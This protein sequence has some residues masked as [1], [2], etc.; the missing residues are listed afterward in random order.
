MSCLMFDAYRFIISLPIDILLFCDENKIDELSITS[1]II[2]YL[3]SDVNLLNNLL[4]FSIVS[5]LL[6]TFFKA[7]VIKIGFCVFSI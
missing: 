6:S 4:I 5:F 7:E 2:L 3:L 1:E